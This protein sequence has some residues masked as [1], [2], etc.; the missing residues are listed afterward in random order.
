MSSRL[1]PLNPL[2]AFEATA[3]RLSV[4]EAARELHV[5]HSAVSHQIRALESTLGVKLFFREAGRLQLTP[6]GAAFLP[7]ISKA[8]DTIAEASA[9]VRHPS[10]E[11][12]LSISCV[13]GL[14][15]F[16]LV[17]NIREFIE[18]FPNVRLR[19]TPSNDTTDL[20]SRASDIC[21]RYGDGNWSGLS[22]KLLST[23]SLFPVC[24][25]ALVNDRPLRDVSDL[26]DHVL[27]H[28]DEGREWKSWLTACDALYLSRCRHHFLSDAHLA[29]EAATFGSGIALGDTITTSHLLE[30]GRLV[31]PFDMA[32]PASQSFFVICRNEVKST[33]LV[34]AFTDWLY[35]LIQRTENR[36]SPVQRQRPRKRGYGAAKVSRQ[37][38]SI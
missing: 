19:V 34:R 25:P 13:P 22:V 10:T 5:T 33:P 15:S 4:T 6:E 2:R 11:G 35:S 7:S 24:S 9:R 3:R 1:P 32:I 37:P 8:F 36:P 27:L 29:V 16:W 21:I 20:H 17:P 18:Q 30:T 28:G 12:D 14:L 31:M 38:V 23:L 26:I